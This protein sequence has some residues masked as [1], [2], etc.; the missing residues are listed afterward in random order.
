[1]KQLGVCKRCDEPIYDWPPHQWAEV[2]RDVVHEKC[3]TSDEREN[4]ERLH[5]MPS[6]GSSIESQLE[7]KKFRDNL[8]WN[9]R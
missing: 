5:G 2:W 6:Q 4:R 1:M 9:K 7:R 3:L 8:H